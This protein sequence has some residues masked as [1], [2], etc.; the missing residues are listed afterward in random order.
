[1]ANTVPQDAFVLSKWPTKI[2]WTTFVGTTIYARQSL[3]KTPENNPV[4]LAYQLFGDEQHNALKDG[5][6]CWDLTA[7]WLA[8]RGPGDLW[9]EISGHW[10]V[11][12]PG[13][14]GTW[15]DDTT[16]PD[17][18]IIPRMPNQDVDKLIEEELSRPPKL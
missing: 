4:R 1:M 15:I 14:Y 12:P 13:G 18:L 16:K 3:Q 11:N 7:A 2:A 8:V 10:R 9:D 6:Q 17:R 5:R